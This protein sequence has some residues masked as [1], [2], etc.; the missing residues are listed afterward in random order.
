MNSIHIFQSTGTDF[1]VKISREKPHESFVSFGDQVR[2]TSFSFSRKA[3]HASTGTHGLTHLSP[4]LTTWFFSQSRKTAG[5]G[6]SNGMISGFLFV[7]S[8]N[9]FASLFGLGLSPFYLDWVFPIFSLDCFTLKSPPRSRLATAT[10]GFRPPA[11]GR[12]LR[13]S[14]DVPVKSFGSGLWLQHAA[15]P[16][17]VLRRAAI[18]AQWRGRPMYAQC[19]PPILGAVAYLSILL[20]R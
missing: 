17:R 16:L 9:F 7:F 18:V 3:Y 4:M 12:G 2:N 13:T 5:K 19:S 15:M 1:F 11:E 8:K 20:F 10:T 14:V 6:H